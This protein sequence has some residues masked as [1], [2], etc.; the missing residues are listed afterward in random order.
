MMFRT[1]V[2]A[3]TAFTLL[4][5]LPQTARAQEYGRPVLDLMYDDRSYINDPHYRGLA[6]QAVRYYKYQ[7]QNFP[8]QKFRRHY[9]GTSWYDP[10]TDKLREDLLK[11]AYDLTNSK[12]QEVVKQAKKNY[13]EIVSNHMGNIGIIMEALALAREDKRFGDPGFF[14]WMRDGLIQVIIGSGDGKTLTSAYHTYTADEETMLV[15][16]LG[17][18][19]INTEA[20]QEGRIAYNMHLVRDPKTNREYTIFIDVTRAM[21]KIQN[22]K[23]KEK[24]GIGLLRQ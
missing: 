4:A 2:L 17:L 9:S 15:A 18:K 12:D 23:K 14:R 24:S 8:F 5:T 13:E 6:D 22:S 3:V 7:P 19:L 20:R 21:A 16:Y 10:V 11:S 1:V